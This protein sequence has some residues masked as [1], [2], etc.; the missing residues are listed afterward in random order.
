[1]RRARKGFTLVELLIV[2]AIIGVLGAMMTLSGTDSTVAAK[3]ASIANGYKIIGTAYNLYRAVS[4]DNATTKFFNDNKVAYLGP[5]A[6][7]IGK[8]TVTSDDTTHPNHVFAVYDFTNDAKV[9]AKF[10]TY[11]VDMGM[12]ATKTLSGSQTLSHTLKMRIY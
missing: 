3:A 6:K 10:G 1:M 8:F 5:Q 11:S 12:I 9:L 2:I 7:D 4:G